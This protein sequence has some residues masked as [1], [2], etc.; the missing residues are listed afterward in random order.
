[1]QYMGGKFRIR[2]QISSYLRSVRR[3]KVYY[4]PFVGAA[5]VLSE[6]DGLR[7]AA[8]GN[9]ALIRM[10]QEL[11]MGWVP[12]GEVSEEMYQEVKRRMDMDDPL[13]AFVG[14]GCSFGGKWFGGYA[15]RGSR[16]YALNAKNSLLEM[17]PRIRDA[18]FSY[19]MYDEWEP[20]PSLIYCD[21]PYRETTAYGALPSFDHD[22][23]W[24]VMREWS[25]IADVYISEYQAPEDFECVLEIF[26]RTDM[27]GKEGAMLS[28][29]ERLFRWRGK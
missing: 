14:F 15:A 20:K 5:W 9:K 2:K 22:K 17:L 8:D 3:H 29:I 11:Q 16:N 26:T 13:T 1:M 12:P 21:P 7:A 6:M 27:R 19:R 24:Q 25:R 4:E 10:Y 23:F 18:K 28:R